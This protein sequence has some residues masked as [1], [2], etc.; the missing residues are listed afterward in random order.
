[1]TIQRKGTCEPAPCF[2]SCSSLYSS[3]VSHPR[4]SDLPGLE[5]R[6]FLRPTVHA[7]SD[8]GGLCCQDRMAGIL[9]PELVLVQVWPPRLLGHLCPACSQ[10]W[11]S[12]NT[13]FNFLRAV[14]NIGFCPTPP[15]HASSVGVI[16]SFRK[17]RPPD[18]V[19]S[20]FPS[21]PSSLLQG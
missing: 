3:L 5:C 19:P 20:T 2:L 18:S 12:L 15:S 21:G 14:V 1:M 8:S 7:W 6:S 10:V 11:I 17:S 9:V 13:S 16:A 4:L